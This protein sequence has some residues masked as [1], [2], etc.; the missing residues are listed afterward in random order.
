MNFNH[1][2]SNSDLAVDDSVFLPL[3]EEVK[4]KF[5]D[6]AE[7]LIDESVLEGVDQNDAAYRVDQHFAPSYKAMFR[8]M[9]TEHMVRNEFLKRHPVH[10]T[11]LKQPQRF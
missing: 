11:I 10:K 3:L 8:K 7:S 5:S 9:I 2:I 1:G 6:Q 4:Q